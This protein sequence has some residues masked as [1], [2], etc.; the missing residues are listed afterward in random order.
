LKPTLQDFKL[1]DVGSDTARPKVVCADAQPPFD[2]I[3][4][5]SPGE[6]DSRSTRGRIIVDQSVVPTAKGPQAL[7]WISP[8][9]HCL[10]R[11]LFV[12]ANVRQA[13]LPYSIE[14]VRLALGWPPMGADQREIGHGRLL[15]SRH[16]NDTTQIGRRYCDRS[17]FGASPGDPKSRWPFPVRQD[18]GERSGH[19]GQRL[20]T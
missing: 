9:Q 3:A 1:F 6:R 2:G 14:D 17:N 11:A 12:V 20:A 13:K 7:D 15:S 19:A 5:Q 16:W 8:M 18:G 4:S 10:G